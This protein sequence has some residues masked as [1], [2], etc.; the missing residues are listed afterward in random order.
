[1]SIEQ[2]HEHLGVLVKAARSSNRVLMWYRKAVSRKPIVERLVE[3]YNLITGK[4]DMLVRCYQV[5]PEA[6]W[7]TFMVHKIERLEV[8]PEIY[9]P[10]RKAT[11][12]DAELQPVYEPSPFWTDARK[13]Y[14]DIVC[15]ALADG[16]VSAQEMTDIKAFLVDRGLTHDDTRYVHASL[17]H[18]CLGAVLEDGFVSEDE[19][20]E[21]RFLHRVFAALGWTVGQ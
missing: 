18:R 2:Q 8:T 17:Y 14:R 1:M 19:V 7:R 21:I 10:R 15:D 20:K 9:H 4:Q 3:P 16:N 5:G 6:G 13:D 12:C 11:I